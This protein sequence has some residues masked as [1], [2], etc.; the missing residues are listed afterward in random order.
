MLSRQRVL[1][2]T[3]STSKT[4]PDQD[5]QQRFISTQD[6]TAFGEIVRRYLDLVMATALRRVNGGRTLAEDI[7]QVVFADLARQARTLPKAVLL[8]GWLHRHTWFVASK[9]VRS[10]IRRRHRETSADAMQNT[11]PEINRPVSEMSLLLDYG[12]MALGETDRQALVMRY[13]EGRDLKSIG[14]S[15]GISNDTAQKRVGRAL[16]K[17]KQWLT[18]RSATAAGAASV[19]ALLMNPLPASA[20]APVLVEAISRRALTIA[21]ASGAGTAGG[22]LASTAGKAALIIAAA[23]TVGLPCY[24]LGKHYRNPGSQGSAITAKVSPVLAS[25]PAFSLGQP[26]RP[27][28]PTA[29][30]DA[31]ATADQLIQ[32]TKFSVP[33]V[34]G[35]FEA[36]KLIR[37]LDPGSLPELA[38]QITSRPV[39]WR[40]RGAA[41]TLVLCEWARTEP[42][43]AMALAEGE[44]TQARVL[45][46]W[47]RKDPAA[48][49]A[50]LGQQF[51]AQGASK[52]TNLMLCAAAEQ[53]T[54]HRD[55]PGALQLAARLVSPENAAGTYS[56]I[57]RLL[58]TAPERGQVHS[59]ITQLPDAAVRSMALRGFIGSWANSDREAAR[60]WIESQ[61]V[62]AP[63]DAMTAAYG[64][65][66]VWVDPEATADWWLNRSFDKTSAV[67]GILGHWRPEQINRAGAWL[68]RQGFGPQAD[69]GLAAFAQKALPQDPESA[70]LWSSIISEPGLRDRT[71]TEL[72]QK[73]LG[74]D[75]ASACQFLQS[76]RLPEGVKAVLAPPATTAP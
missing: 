16:E 31:T 64:G 9:T 48:A 71:A 35:M 62:S 26:D 39:D 14:V 3:M 66:W 22:W 54:G 58:E 27:A 72:Y 12:M 40:L 57:T 76:L 10:E 11:T 61:P 8:G 33:D 51:A 43:Q 49:T 18:S 59:A 65:V 24:F 70:L 50:W 68:K 20:A 60:S 37:S 41:A 4:T 44:D 21:S 69:Q 36:V 74:A 13:L 1:Q 73:W 45:Q 75:A 7:L 5:L 55:L 67:R 63:N 38:K 32:L 6:E 53:L 25:S 42:A 30:T 52:S 29:L 15:L 34:D 23:V 56:S 47:L 17:L 19:L 28:A 46:Y 2:G